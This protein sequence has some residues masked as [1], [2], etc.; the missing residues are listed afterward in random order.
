MRNYPEIFTHWIPSKECCGVFAKLF[1]Q[2]NFIH[3][4]HYW[5]MV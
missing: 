4:M 1:V 3:G 2:E 5:I